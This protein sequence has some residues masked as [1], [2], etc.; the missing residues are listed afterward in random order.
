VEYLQSKDFY[1][2]IINFRG[3]GFD[4]NGQEQSL[5]TPHIY[6]GISVSDFVEPAS[7]IYQKYCKNQ[8]RKVFGLGVSIGSIIMSLALS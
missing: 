4:S 5:K 6:S 1:V 2:V 7:Y 3:E 8:K